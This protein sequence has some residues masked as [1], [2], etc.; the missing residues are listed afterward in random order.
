MKKM[1]GRAGVFLPVLFFVV[2]AASCL[3]VSC[4]GDGG[5]FSRYAQARDLYA[6]GRFPEASNILSEMNDFVPAL[7][8]RAKAE[9][10][11]GNLAEAESLCKKAI[12]RRPSSFEAKFY[13]AKILWERGDLSRCEKIVLGLL[14]DNPGDVRT[15]R[16]ASEL[17]MD[18]G[19]THEAG[20][21][22]DQAAE[23]S[24]E[25]AMVFLDRARLRWTAG[26][27]VDALDDL[28][29]AGT[30]LP[31]ESPVAKS[32]EQLKSIIKEAVK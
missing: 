27:G 7:I 24:A 5:D 30:L 22:L 26:R 10:F 6:S 2:L 14:A 18:R 3:A 31:V 25:S 20:A 8:L 17:A 29:R 28:D 1:M 21:L 13:L 12:R 9:Y 11:S 4:S 19:K 16:F 23:F 15:L 32:I